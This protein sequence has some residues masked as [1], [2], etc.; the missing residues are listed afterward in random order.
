MNLET[1][2][3]KS[4]PSSFISGQ[5]ECSHS[6]GAKLLPRRFENALGQIAARVDAVPIELPLTVDF[7]IGRYK[8][9]VA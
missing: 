2:L 4:P 3:A 9:T 1:A 7:F 6:V 8:L 5:A